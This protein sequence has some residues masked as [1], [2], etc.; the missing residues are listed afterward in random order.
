MAEPQ[1]DSFRTNPKG[2]TGDS[3]QV[4]AVLDGIA[5]ALR[6][7]CEAERAYRTG[8]DRAAGLHA[9]AD[10]AHRNL[11]RSICELSEIE[12]D[13]VEPSFTELETRLLRLPIPAPRS[14]HN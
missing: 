7:T 3:P 14:F 11:L 8:D 5:E 1:R 2:L 9:A 12:A 10:R 4:M 13:H 6:M